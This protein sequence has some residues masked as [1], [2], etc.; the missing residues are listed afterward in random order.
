MT[1]KGIIFDIKQLAVFDGPGIRTTV[2]FKGCPLRCQW[3]HNPEGLMFQ[4]Q[5]LIKPGCICCGKCKKVCDN[6]NKCIACG[7]CV[8]Y[9]PLHLRS[10]CGMEYDADDLA[11]LLLRDKDYLEECN[12]GITFSGGEPLSQAD[13]I[14]TLIDRLEGMHTA[15]E[16]SGYSSKDV[17]HMLTQKV[18]LVIM[19]IKIVDRQAHKQ[20]TGVDNKPII[21]NLRLLKQGYTPYIIR[22]P[23]IPGV[24][25]S[26]ANL[27]AIAQLLENAKKMVKVELLTYHQT[28]GAKY[29]HVGLTYQPSF[30][31]KQTPNTNTKPFLERGIVCD[32]L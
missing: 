9:C 29:K 24:T 18:N 12:G 32:I 26:N 17:F 10:I 28:A 19:D 8:M 14:S 27:T 23:I 25:D 11:S 30:N 7:K 22:V 3:C 4:P 16:T 31:Q 13:F 20:Y 21:E 1:Q 5:L 2:F 15:I 6:P